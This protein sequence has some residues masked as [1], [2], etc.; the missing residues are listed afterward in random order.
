MP[1]EVC[2]AR[3]PAV[4]GTLLGSCVAVAVYDPVGRVGGMCHAMLPGASPRHGDL[5]HLERALPFLFDAIR[6]TGSDPR[7]WVLKA[8]GGAAV[9]D[10]IRSPGWDV[11]ERNIE[12]LR[13]ILGR[14]G[15]P[16]A[17]CDLGGTRGR[18][19]RFHLADGLVFV[20]LLKGPEGTGAP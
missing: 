4:V 9:I 14:E 5:R 11:G 13:E 16:L 10:T 2:T 15:F 7:R 6:A 20:R 3:A 18:R 1:G 8:F 17:S 12:K 19:L